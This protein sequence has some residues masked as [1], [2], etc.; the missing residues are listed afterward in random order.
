MI[1]RKFRKSDAVGASNCIHAA[2]H[3]ILSKHYPKK[4]ITHLEAHFSPLKLVKDSK[5]T[6]ALVVLSRNKIVG[7]ARFQHRRTWWINALFVEPS[8]H[9]RG[10]GTKLLAKL[11]RAAKRKGV[12]TLKVNAGINAPGF[13]E[14]SGYG[15]VKKLKK[16]GLWVYVMR[17]KI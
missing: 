11:E 12:K 1:I 16:K 5:K 13:Y 9:G 6:Y 10:I 7:F 3:K 17:K 4:F 8:L 15:L 14:K 2:L